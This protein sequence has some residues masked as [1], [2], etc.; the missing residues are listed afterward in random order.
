[1]GWDGVGVWGCIAAKRGE[2]SGGVF[3]FVSFIIII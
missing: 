1:M 2:H 3:T